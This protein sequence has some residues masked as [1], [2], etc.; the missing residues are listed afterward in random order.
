MAADIELVLAADPSTFALADGATFTATAT[1][2][3]STPCKLD[4]MAEG[5]EFVIRSGNDEW[6]T[7]AQCTG[8]TPFGEEAYVLEPGADQAFTLAWNGG[9]GENG[10]AKGGD[11]KAGA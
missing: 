10:C 4:A 3:A 5:T 6:F 8:A 2:V 7:T 9:R 1:S 11:A